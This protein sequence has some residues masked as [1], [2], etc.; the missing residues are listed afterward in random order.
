MPEENKEQVAPQ[1]DAP[2]AAVAAQGVQLESGTY[3]II[4]SRLNAHGGDLKARMEQLNHA[5]KQVFGSIDFKLIGSEHITTANNCVPRDVIPVG[6]LFIFGYN[7]FIGMRSETA[8]SDVFAIYRWKD[9]RFEPQDLSLLNNDE[10]QTDFRNLYKYYKNTVFY[11]F[12]II[13]PHLFMAFQVGKDFTDLKTFKWL[14]NGDTLSYVD[15]RSDHEFVLPPQHGFEWRRAT[16]DMHVSG[17]HPHISIEDRVFV[18]T[19]GG[20][21]TVKVENNTA[22]G[23]GIYSE[24]VDNPDQTLD[25]AEIFYAILGNI[26]L[27]KVRPYQERAFR[28]IVYNCRTQQAVRVDSIEDSCILL[29]D[30]HGIIF[31]RGYYLQTGAMK[32]FDGPVDDMVFYKVI[33][34]PNGEDFLYAFYNRVVGLYILL[35]YNLISQEVETPIFCNGFSLFEDGTMVFFRADAEPAKHHAVQIWQ[36][37]YMSVNCPPDVLS[38]SYLY[39]VGNKDIVRCLAE[40]SEVLTLVRKEDTYANLYVDIARQAQAIRDSYHWLDHPDTFDL[41]VPLIAIRAA[42]DSAI[43]EFDKVVRTKAATRKELARVEARV[44]EVV[45]SINYYGL[46]SINEFVRLLAG[47]RSVRGEIISCRDLRYVELPAVEAMEREV[48]EHNDKLSNLCVEFLLKPA[49][50]EPYRVK[51]AQQAAAVPGLKKVTEAKDLEQQVAASA[52]ELEMLIEIVSNLKIADA[53]AT[54]AIIDSISLVFGR[55]NQVRSTLKNRLKELAATEGRA[56]FNSQVKLL[57]Q[58]VTNYLDVCDTPG[59][60]DEYLTKLMVQVETL[61]SRFADFDEFVVALAQKREEVYNAFESRKVQLVEDRNRRASALMTAAG[62][63][64]KGIASRAGQLGSINEINGYFAGDLMI[65][66]VR[67]TIAQLQALGDTVKADDIASQLKTIQQ[68]A[69]RQLKDRQGL[70]ED[71]LNVIRLGNHRF[72][73]NRQDLEL[74]IVH[75]DGG[76]FLHLTGTGF[77][78]EI[79][80]EAFLA[81]RGVWHL[82]APSESPQVYRAEYLAHL[83]FQEMLDAATIVKT[84]LEELIPQVQAFMSERFA[85]AYVKG[86]H[87]HDAARILKALAEVHSTAGLLRYDTRARAAATLFW[88]VWADASGSGMGVSPMRPTGVSPVAGRLDAHYQGSITHGQ[89]AHE[90]HGRDAHATKAH[91]AAQLAGFGQMRQVFGPRADAA[92]YVAQLQ[93]PMKAFLGAATGANAAAVPPASVGLFAE[94]YTAQAAD[95][96]FQELIAPGPGFVLAKMAADLRAGFEGHLRR[97][98]H[99]DKLA[100][101]L[102]QLTAQPLAQF[103]L[104]RDWLHAYVADQSQDSASEYVDEAAV[105]M[106]VD[107][108]CANDAKRQARTAPAETAAPAEAAAGEMTGALAILAADGSRPILDAAVVRTVEGMVGSHPLLVQGRYVLNVGQFA[109]R[110]A[111]HEQVVVPQFVQYQRTKKALVERASAELKLDEFR[112][113]VLTTFVRNRLLDRVYLPLIGD[114]L[115]KQIGTADATKRTDRQGMLLLISPPGYGKTTLMEYV[116]NRLGLIFIKVNGPAIGNRVTSLDP[117]E[118]PNAAAREEL[119]KLNLGIEMGDNV[120]L[121]VDD[122]QH[123]NPEFLQ[124]F[125]SLCD[126]QRKIEGVYK[127]RTRTY[128]LRGKRVCVVMAGNPYTESGQRFKIPDMLANR[129]DTYNIGDIVGN[130]YDDFCL[131]YIENC[132][133]ANPVLGKLATRSQQDLYEMIKL[134]QGSPREQ[135]QL[136]AAYSVDELQ[137][138]VAVMQKLFTV[139]DVVLKVNR[140]YI[141]SAGQEAAYRTEP[142]F[143]LQGSYRNMNRIAAKVLAVMNEEELWTQVFSA[144]EQDSQTLT[145]SAESNMLKFKELLGRL[146]EDEQRRWEEIKKTFGRNQL[147]G[148][149][150]DDK[151]GQVIRQLN[152]FGANLEG[153]KDVIAG[154]VAAISADGNGK[155]NDAKRQAGADLQQHLAAQTAAVKEQSAAMKEQGAAIK[156]QSAAIQAAM[157][158]VSTRMAEVI[159][160][161]RDQH[162]AAATKPSAAQA[163]QVRQNADML[164]SVLDEQFQ[165]MQTWLSPVVKSEEGRS[166]YVEQLVR[167]FETMVEGY[168][169]LIGVLK[170]KYDGDGGTD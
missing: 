161:L 9:G 12:A 157:M 97:G 92:H 131:S 148:D 28:Y 160:S 108:S 95:Y 77:F 159:Q 156:E 99:S 167:R 3:E 32:L 102:S 149:K 21:L 14:I 33:P 140:Q 58:A 101:T 155:A 122:I 103:R 105:A 34:A 64:L 40:C 18:E 169:R 38:E 132:L 51:V 144:Y 55:I 168:Q 165:T 119:L 117:A 46:E 37:P 114:N 53:T 137:E 127:G 71:G 88:L 47:L 126:A 25:D 80:D 133:T 26:V 138:L 153:I 111:H 91:L 112:P 163:A 106:L 166:E 120:M 78:E 154:G 42:A 86:V 17:E 83:M 65:E 22:T 52:G 142:P 29:P 13:G 123:C 69:V 143:L 145:A 107:W 54:T 158:Q 67:E 129:S 89:D 56:E 11:K 27:L 81:T 7:V 20:D 2:V 151:V 87:D 76:M 94:D 6:S 61:E 23:E 109:S 135:V 85:E 8:L 90:T 130:S 128:D 75:R 24:P 146:T 141:A 19:I 66:R 164:V 84:P 31:P 170:S 39:K 73:V 121:Y 72:N 104:L 1:V 50:L 98:G 15:N 57:D 59:K 115:A 48:A 4:R 113:K 60:T 134:A 93:G 100:D 125:I 63:V 74:T 35:S 136:E 45:G 41:S 139:R 116:A 70:F 49:A 147:L 82:D 152:A 162:T 43:G 110:L 68:D 96:L 30:D 79:T 5:R 150:T 10:F 124:K 16:R 62:R 36:T 118:A 44:R